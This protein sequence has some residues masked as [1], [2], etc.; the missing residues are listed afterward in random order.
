MG[1]EPTVEPLPGRD[2]PVSEPARFDAEAE[3][4]AGLSAGCHADNSA[5]T[6]NEGGPKT[7][8]AA[9]DDNTGASTDSTLSSVAAAMTGDRAIFL[10]ILS[11]TVDADNSPAV[12]RSLHREGNPASDEAAAF[13]RLV[14]VAVDEVKPST[15]ATICAALA[16]RTV[17]RSL[18]RAEGVFG[19][20]DGEA[21]LAAWLDAARA[22]AAARGSDGLRRLLPTARLLARRTAGRGEPAAEIATTMRRIAARI[23]ADPSLGRAFN[24]PPEGYEHDRM[25]RGMSGPPRRIVIHGPV[26]I[27]FP[28]R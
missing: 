10:R 21:L 26:E 12:R 11:R 15:A 5:E 3:E 28:A 24:D 13:E 2:D 14:A 18:L 9:P 7:F 20:S 25:L 27:T 22:V 4:A 23:A 19:T 1:Q 17:A 6:G 16:A 8:A